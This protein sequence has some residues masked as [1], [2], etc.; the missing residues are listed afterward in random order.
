MLG[1]EMSP[2]DYIF[3]IGLWTNISDAEYSTMKNLLEDTE[4]DS[5]DIL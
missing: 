4:A 5:L 1:R 3:L 2:R